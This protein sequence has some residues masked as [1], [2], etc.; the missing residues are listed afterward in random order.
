MKIRPIFP[1]NGQTVILH[2]DVQREFLR[3]NGNKGKDVTFDYL[4]LVRQ[5][6]ERTIPHPVTFEWE[7]IS[8][9]K[10]GVVLKL[11]EN[12][13]FTSFRQYNADENKL[14]V[15]NLKIGHKYFWKLCAGENEEK[16]EETQVFS[17]HTSDIP[18][19]WISADGLG[20][21]RD[22]GG[23]TAGDDK[24]IKQGLVY[25]GCEMEFHYTLLPKGK[26]VLAGELC[27]K[28]DLDLRAEAVDKITSSAIGEDCKL[29][30]IPTGAY[31]DFLENKEACK[32]IFSLLA[33]RDNYPFYVHCWGGADRTG[34]VIFLLS[35]ILGVKREDLFL[36]YELTSLSVWGERSSD[37]ER[38]KELLNA[39]DEYGTSDDT[40][41]KK[42]ENYI[43]STGVTS[44]E[45]EKIRSILL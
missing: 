36:D 8:E 15:T 39:L 35:A 18:P 11:S 12:S 24:K 26:K 37:S 25:R 1:T 22:I 20:N 29:R 3:C 33:S 42:C 2:T 21:I 13:D 16:T 45:I 38:F 23:W 14:C 10:Q 40:I 19:R 28:T 6:E 31:A 5:K 7:Y 4:N 41:N 17:F 30:L 34:T 43:M 44:E 9:K 32:E 27:I